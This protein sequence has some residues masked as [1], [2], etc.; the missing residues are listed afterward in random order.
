MCLKPVPD[1]VSWDH[2]SQR[3]PSGNP[4]WPR[5]LRA[6]RWGRNRPTLWNLC[7]DQNA[8]DGLLTIH[9]NPKC[10]WKQN[11]VNFLIP[12]LSGKQCVPCV[13]IKSVTVEFCFWSWVIY[14][15]ILLPQDW[16]TLTISQTTQHKQ[17]PEYFVIF[18]NTFLLFWLRKCSKKPTEWWGWQ[19]ANFKSLTWLSTVG[20]RYRFLFVWWNNLYLLTKRST[21]EKPQR[22]K[23]YHAGEE[24]F[25]KLYANKSRYRCHLIKS[26][27][28]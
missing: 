14:I 13:N 4:T 7:F 24:V 20:I 1:V 5:R 15:W 21:E 16:E 11:G 9:E 10:K 19:W 27:D 2:G 28:F 12:L 17:C 25:I 6:N 8:T 23:P 26:A 22:Y 3:R 18:S